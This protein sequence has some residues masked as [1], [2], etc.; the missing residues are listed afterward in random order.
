MKLTSPLPPSITNGR[1]FFK[2][3]ALKAKVVNLLNN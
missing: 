1:I 3:S 2:N